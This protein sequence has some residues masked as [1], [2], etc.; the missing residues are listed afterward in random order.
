[1]AY[2]TP[3]HVFR[4]ARNFEA[5]LR[6]I[7][8]LLGMDPVPRT[9][10]VSFNYF[11]EHNFPAGGGFVLCNILEQFGA[12]GSSVLVASGDNGVGAPERCRKFHVEFPS[13]C[14]C[15]VYHPFQALQ[16]HQYMSLTR[17]CFLGPWVTSVC[18]TQ[19]LP[20]ERAPLVSSIP[21]CI[22]TKYSISKASMTS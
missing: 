6:V 16:K 14:T 4:V 8:F 2:P 7:I 21:G 10:S 13:T 5:F 3:L 15:D 17:P 18:C 19:N 22:A 9:V 11:L 20:P 12:L 1:M